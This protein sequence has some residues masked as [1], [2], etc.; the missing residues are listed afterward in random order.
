M[1]KDTSE[2]YRRKYQEK[3]MEMDRAYAMEAWE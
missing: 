2:S 3:K 1:G